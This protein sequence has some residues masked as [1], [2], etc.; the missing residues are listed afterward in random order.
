MQ[1]DHVSLGVT[2][3]EKSIAFYTHIIGLTPIDRPQFTFKGAWFHIATGQQ[4]HLIEKETD[5][6]VRSSGTRSNHFALLVDDI[7]PYHH[8]CV[9]N[10]I[11][12][13]GPKQRPDGM[14]Q[15]FIP[16]PDKHYIEL[17]AKE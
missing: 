7:L 2:D 3:V 14:W 4:L 10:N 15:L 16:D 6:I 17:T 11:D 12:V 9:E 1:I 13:I 5:P 8:R